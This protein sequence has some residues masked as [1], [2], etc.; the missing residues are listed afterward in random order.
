M[1][2]QIYGSGCA[3]CQKLSENAAAAIQKLGIDCELEKITDLDRIVEAGVMLTPALAIDGKVV[4]TG[5]VLSAD[6]I[7]GLLSPGGDGGTAAPA[8]AASCGCGGGKKYLTWLLLIFVLASVAW[9]VVRETRSVKSAPVAAEPVG[10]EVMTVYYFHGNQR[11][12]TCN[13]IEELA[14]KAIEAR[15]GRELAD[16][17][18]RF[19][20]VNVEEPDNAHF[21]NDFDLTV[22][23]VVIR[24]GKNVEKFDEV[25]TLVHE[26]DKLTAYIQDGA[27]QMMNRKD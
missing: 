24:K 23:S 21:I 4:S 18:V 17:R 13:R 14:R 20:S 12:M 2:M 7:A 16:G 9:M 25:W 1:R 10:N 5:T 8:P 22:R 19:L 26:P 27:A 15:Y 11:C 3:K 6:A